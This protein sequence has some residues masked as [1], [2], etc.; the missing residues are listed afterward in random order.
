M[1]VGYSN[2]EDG[3]YEGNDAEEETGHDVS[4]VVLPPVHPGQRNRYRQGEGE[5]P[6]E[7]ACPPSTA[8]Y[9]NDERETPVQRE[10]GRGVT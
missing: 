9:R 4:R 8:C 7:N 3:S 6:H 5:R 1:Y 2:D 10:G